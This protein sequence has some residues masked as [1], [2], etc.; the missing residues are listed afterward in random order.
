MQIEEGS[1]LQPPTH[2][3]LFIQLA[4]IQH[5]LNGTTVLGAGDLAVTDK[6]LSLW[7]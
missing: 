2:T 3:H 7:T 4:F 5:M 1:F 6:F